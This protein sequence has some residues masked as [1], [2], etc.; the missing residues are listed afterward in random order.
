MIFSILKLT[1]V[2][3]S[4]VDVHPSTYLPSGVQLHAGSGV[5]VHLQ[6]DLSLTACL[7]ILAIEK[8]TFFEQ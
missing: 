3:P 8:R 4:A 1:H 2:I 5:N 7:A 6:P